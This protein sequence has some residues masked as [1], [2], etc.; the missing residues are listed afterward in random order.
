[1]SS[2]VTSFEQQ[3][4]EIASQ[5]FGL[6]Q[7]GILESMAFS[8]ASDT[9]ELQQTSVAAR[10]ILEQQ[11]VLSHS[12]PVPE[13]GRAIPEGVYLDT[14]R[15][16]TPEA[17]RKA[18][19]ES[20]IR[21]LTITSPHD[22]LLFRSEEEIKHHENLIDA[23][24]YRYQEG[25]RVRVS[26]AVAQVAIRLSSE[27]V[28]W[29][30]A[31][32]AVDKEAHNTVR[33]LDDSGCDLIGQ[34]AWFVERALLKSPDQQMTPA[35]LAKAIEPYP[36]DTVGVIISELVSSRILIRDIEAGTVRLNMP[37]APRGFIAVMKHVLRTLIK[38]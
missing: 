33:L 30:I 26:E 34:A 18:H 28:A 23:Y 29:E 3:R 15:H 17:Y 36:S 25:N 11:C 5:M 37:D 24:R 6:D 35:E 27:Q 10:Y 7:L 13:E 31:H 12:L 8:E 9:F 16:R 14:L 22:A 21:E 1:M 19:L 4:D 32:G 38:G 20:R 2:P